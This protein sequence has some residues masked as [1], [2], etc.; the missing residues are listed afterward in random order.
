[1]LYSKPLQN[2]IPFLKNLGEAAP[3]RLAAED[4]LR[5]ARRQ[6]QR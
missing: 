3:A 4:T 2:N 5:T 1:M 6:Q